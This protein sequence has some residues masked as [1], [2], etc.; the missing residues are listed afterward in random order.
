M[1][2]HVIVEAQVRDYGFSPAQ[3]D[4]IWRRWREGQSFSLI[5]RALGAPM[6]HVRQFLYQSG[7]IRLTPQQRSKR[8]LT[9]SEREEISRGI[10]A[11]ESARQLAR[12]LG[13]SPS[14]VSREIARNGGRDRYRAA[15]ADTVAYVRGRRPKQAKL[16]QRPTLRALVETKL[17]L[18]WS[19]EQ[20]AGWLRFQFPGDAAMQVSHEAI[21]L[22][23]YDPRRRQAIDR[24]LT[25]RLRSA[26]PMRRPKIARR[27]TGRG[28]I[29]GMV[30]ISA[31]PAEV[32]D[33]KIPGHWEGDLVMGT[34]PSAV[35]T[36]VERTSRYTAIVALPDGIKAEQVTPHLTRSLLGIPPQLRRT[37]TWDRGREIAEHQA[38]TSETGM[39]I[40]LCKPR[41]PWQRGT[42]ENTNRLLRQYLGKGADLRTFSQADLDAIAHELNHRPRKTH[43]YRTPAEVYADLLN[44]GDALTA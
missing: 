22:S 17:A 21:Y 43:G 33:R 35:A 31:R 38:I 13:R 9:G 23:L 10:A 32:E 28:I 14:T 3:Q 6:H 20:I 29:R 15:S 4:E 40:Y 11:G 25:Q 7:G 30:S 2:D 16:A 18:C 42:N 37:L 41:S 19:P 39:P 34:R 26:R 36:L 24:S 44:S 27:P 8:H 12:R 1:D 5:G